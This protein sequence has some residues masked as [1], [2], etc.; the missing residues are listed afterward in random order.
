MEG[1][2]RKEKDVHFSIFF[3]G[4]KQSKFIHIFELAKL[5]IFYKP[6]INFSFLLLSNN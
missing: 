4:C 1:L 5:P 3:C 2:S 6:T